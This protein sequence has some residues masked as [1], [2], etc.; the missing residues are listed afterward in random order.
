MWSRVAAGAD[1]VAD[2][3]DRQTAQRVQARLLAPILLP[4]SP[5]LRVALWSPTIADPI[6]QFKFSFSI[7]NDHQN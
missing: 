7:E 6:D 2:C 3:G 5:F 1:L 4:H